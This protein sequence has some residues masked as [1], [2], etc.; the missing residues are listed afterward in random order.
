MRSFDFHLPT[1][2]QFGRGLLRKLGELAAPLGK[3]AILVGYRDAGSLDDAYQRAATG[4]EKAGVRVAHFAQVEP[5]P[6]ASL[7]AQGA[8]LAR[9]TGANFVVGLGGGSV[10]DVAKAIALMAGSEGDVSEYFLGRTSARE[11]A[12]ALP[13][14]AV[15]TT[16]G[17]GAE[18]T[19]IAI[20]SQAQADGGRRKESLYGP[21]IRPQLAV[22]DPDLAVGSPAALTAAC[23]ADALGHA[24]EAVTS[25]RANPIASAL[26]IEAVRLASENLLRAVESIIDPAPRE[27]LALAATLAGA[28]F[29]ASSVAVGHALAQTLGARLG[30]AHALAVA[31]ATPIALRFNLP[32]CVEPYARLASACGLSAD[33]PIALA[34]RFVDHIANLLQSVGLP[35]QFPRPADASDAALDA[36]VQETIQG[37]RALLTLNPRRIDLAALRQLFEAS[38]FGT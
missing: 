27:G 16:A 11:P 34:E 24:I 23:A 30:Q 14:V 35:A 12:A 4:L 31:V 33:G 29:S 37:S 25:R 36:L 26:A 13:V 32:E 5:E 22:I 20:L 8:A 28:A 15:P 10:L 3:A 19:D 38:F 2:I 7:V 21:A 1:R 18:V 17:T 9:E 6:Q